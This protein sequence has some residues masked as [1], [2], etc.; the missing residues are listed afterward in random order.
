M[1]THAWLI[2]VG[3]L[4]VGGFAHAEPYSPKKL[5]PL[6]VV[7][8]F[9]GYELDKFP[10]NFRTYPFQRSKA[11]QVYLVKDEGGNKVLHAFDDKD[12][13]VQAF[14]RFPWEVK[15]WPHFSWRWKAVTLPPNADEN[16]G[17]PNDSACGIYVTFGGYTGNAIKYVWSTTLPAGTV[18]EKKPNKFYIV[19]LDSGSGGVGS[20]QTKAVNVLEDHKRL[21][22][23]EPSAD[24]D[25]FG[26]LTDGNATHSPSACDYDDFKVSETP[27]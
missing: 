23:S 16:N 10:K 17:R 5:P 19:V 27:F 11:E 8:D 9:S 18:V 25:G 2:A 3:T 20:W 7:E 4:V 13:S 26:L 6:R 24:P 15:R 12:L 14:K 21:F 22:K 1:K